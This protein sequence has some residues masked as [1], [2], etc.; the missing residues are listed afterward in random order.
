MQEIEVKKCR[1]VRFYGKSGENG[2]GCRT[3]ERRR[4]WHVCQ[5]WNM[6][7]DIERNRHRANNIRSKKQTSWRH[8]ETSTPR[9]DTRIE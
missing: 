9:M 2:I 1:K 3:N 8:V 6:L 4:T 7:D 5:G